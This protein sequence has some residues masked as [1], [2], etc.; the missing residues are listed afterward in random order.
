MDKKTLIKNLTIGFLPLLVF[1][2]ADEL[3]DLVTSLII[4]VA[5]GLIELG[6]TYFREKRFDKFILLD[7]GLIASLGLVSV[8]LENPIFILIKPAIIEAIFAILIGI[9]VFTKNPLLINMSARYMKGMQMGDE[10]I[11]MMRKM[12]H[13]MFWLF[14]LHIALIIA[15]AIYVGEPKS[16]G[17]MHRKEIWAFVSGGLLYILIGI[18][19]VY[20]F[21]KNKVT[22]RRFL[23]QFENDEW[24]DIVTPEGKVIGK[25]PRS[26][27]HG[28]PDLLHPVVHVHVFNSKGDLWLQKRAE[29]KKI[30][31]GKWDTSVGGHISS[32]ESIDKALLREIHEEL[33]VTRMPNEPL[34]RYVMK[35]EIE[36]E[37]VHTFRG[38]HNGPFS[39]PDDEIQDGKFWKIKEIKKNLGKDVFT[40]NFEEEFRM[41][42]KFNLLRVA[43]G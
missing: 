35:N 21:L 32:G 42:S 13:G 30:Q 12:L 34:Y 11:G 19:F 10:Q 22:Q 14:L 18:S 2:I 25:A 3:F 28:N 8:L 36:S 31:P 43:K 17:Y 38:F 9:T 4:A 7:I 16:D 26:I 15:S 39:Y 40:P 29:S 24:F 20:Q 41:L 33:G 1:I 23:K 6:I 5:V 27:C 37:L